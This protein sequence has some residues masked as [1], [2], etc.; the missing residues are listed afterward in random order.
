MADDRI[1]TTVKEFFITEQ[2]CPDGWRPFDLYLFRDE[3]VV[4]YVGQS[5][6]AFDRVWRHLLD[7]FKGR[8]AV[9]RFIL[10]NWPV[11]MRFG[12]ELLSS[13]A[14]QFDPVDNNLNSAEHLLIEQFA[15]CFNIALNGI[16]T[17]IP[18][19][20][21]PPGATIKCSRSLVKLIHQANI[22]VQADTRRAAVPVDE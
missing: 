1:I 12:I 5:Q 3:Q 2:R 4:F 17:P 16:P 8:S 20:Y 10:C 13:R 14:G 15:P 7:G 18:A 21:A 22:A 6:V 9:G 19:K 11:S